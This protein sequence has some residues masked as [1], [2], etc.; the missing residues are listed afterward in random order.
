MEFVDYVIIAVILVIVGVAAWSIYKAKKSGKKC[1]GCPDSC[2]CSSGNCG[3]G[4]SGC[5]EGK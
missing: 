3:C 5:S 2:A 4:C 1:I